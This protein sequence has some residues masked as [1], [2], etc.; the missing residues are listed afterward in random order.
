MKKL[1]F[2]FLTLYQVSAN[3]QNVLEIMTQANEKVKNG[4]FEDAIEDYNTILKLNPS[5]S[6]ALVMKGLSYASINNIDSACNCFIDGIELGSKNSKEYYPKYCNKYKP[7]IETDKF[8][9][10]KFKYLTN[11]SDTSAYFIR[12]NNWQ[13]EYFE[14]STLYAK[15]AIK[16]KSNTEIELKFV[17]TNDDKLSFLKK[18]D[19]MIVKILKVNQDNYVYMSDLFGNISY[20]IL[21]KQK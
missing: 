15:F 3:G 17:E 13:T 14:N 16:W 21:E 9:T 7:N 8:K 1:L 20:G 12:D 18:G 6:M 11:D 5:F 2:L 4:N 19:K 10:G